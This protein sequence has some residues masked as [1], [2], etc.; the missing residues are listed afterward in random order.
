MVIGLLNIQ[1]AQDSS[2]LLSHPRV[3]LLIG[4]KGCVHNLPTLQES[5]LMFINVIDKTWRE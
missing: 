2:G 3:Y 5:H 4:Q 1:L